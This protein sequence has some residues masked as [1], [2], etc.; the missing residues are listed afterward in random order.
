MPAVTGSGES[1]LL[2]DKSADAPTVVVALARLFALFGSLV[3]DAT[4]AV[5][6]IVLLAPNPTETVAVS[7]ALAP[8]FT[9]PRLQGKEAQPPCEEVSETKVTPLGKVSVTFTLV[10]FEG[11]K[12]ATVRTYVKF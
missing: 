1:V 3:E 12:F 8:A 5:L 4:P 10:A 6:V 2:S 11:P 9:V 7:V